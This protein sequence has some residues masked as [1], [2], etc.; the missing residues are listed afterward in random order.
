MLL[1]PPQGLFRV[2][3]GSVRTLRAKAFAIGYQS[4]QENSKDLS[5]RDNRYQPMDSFEQCGTTNVAKAKGGRG[6]LVSMHRRYRFV[7]GHVLVGHNCG[8]LGF[9]F[10]KRNISIGELYFLSKWI[11]IGH[12]LVHD[13]RVLT[14]FRERECLQGTVAHRLAWPSM[15]CAHGQL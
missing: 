15:A 6:R 1:F 4:S 13:D 10:G 5:E 3:P 2:V 9:F 8:R 14:R 7:T 11:A 12:M